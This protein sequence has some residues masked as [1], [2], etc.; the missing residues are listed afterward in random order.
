M[1]TTQQN[2]P[3]IDWQQCLKISNQNPDLATELLSMFMQQ[4]PE[5]KTNI[6]QC[7]QNNQFEELHQHVH[8]LHGATCYCGMQHLQKLLSRF[9]TALKAKHQT[10]YA[11]LITATTEEFAAIE[12]YYQ[13]HLSHE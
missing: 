7:Y 12:H 2:Q 5:Y 8:K 9:E 10:S 6:L 1:D 13:Q 11:Q 3:A 4:L